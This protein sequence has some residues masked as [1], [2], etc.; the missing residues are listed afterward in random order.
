M[1]FDLISENHQLFIGL[2]AGLIPTVITLY[3]QKKIRETERRNWLLRNREAFLIELVDILVGRMLK[4]KTQPLTIR[5]FTWIF[6][7]ILY[8]LFL[9]TNSLLVRFADIKSPLVTYGSARSIRLWNEISSNKDNSDSSRIIRSGEKFLRSIRKDLGIKDHKL[10]P[11][12]L[13]ATL[14]L[15][16]D[17]QQA[18]D[19]C[20]GERYDNL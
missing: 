4:S 17:R 8:C 18:L 11:G 12:E 7:C 10:Q 14:L 2:T 1:F 9:K 6:D 16:K 13:W 19:A 20:K 5:I 3:T 15:S